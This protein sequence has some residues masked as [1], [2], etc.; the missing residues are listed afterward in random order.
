MS[1]RRRWIVLGDPNNRRTILFQTALRELGQPVADVVSYRDLLQGQI[2]LTEYLARFSGET[3]ILRIESPAEDHE[4][5]RRLIAR[6]A[7]DGGISPAAALRLRAD[8]GRV[9]HV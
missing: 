7:S 4:V 9:R 5:E 1:E 6:G 8:V 2:D 3:C